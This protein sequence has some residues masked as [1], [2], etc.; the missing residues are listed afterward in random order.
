MTELVYGKHQAQRM[1]FNKDNYY[2]EVWV[3][4]CKSQ[5]LDKKK[6]KTK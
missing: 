3:F 2:F 4:P 6:A 1:G 5:L